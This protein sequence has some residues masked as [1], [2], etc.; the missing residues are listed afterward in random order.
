MVEEEAGTV[1]KDEEEEEEWADADVQ[2]DEDPA[3][4]ALEFFFGFGF[5][6][7][8]CPLLAW[9]SERSSSFMTWSARARCSS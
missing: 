5:F 3:P 6:F 8:F 9:S 7:F 4:V 1:V 2:Q